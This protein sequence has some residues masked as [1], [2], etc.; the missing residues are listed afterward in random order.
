MKNKAILGSVMVILGFASTPAF[1]QAALFDFFKSTDVKVTPDKKYTDLNLVKN[2]DKNKIVVQEFFSFG[3]PHCSDFASQF[4]QWSAKQPK[5]VTVEKIPVTFDR[6]E[7]QNMAKLYYSLKEMNLG[8]KDADVFNAIHKERV[9]LWDQETIYSWVKSKDIDIDKFKEVYNSEK[10][11][12]Q[13][14]N[15]DMLSKKYK[16]DGVP[17]IVIGDNY[18]ISGSGGF[19]TL[20]KNSDD[21]IIKIH[22][23]DNLK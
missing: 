23:G 22:N 16:I 19:D 11:G 1:S 10:V 13:V 6:P 18:K 17:S 14:K 9:K 21:V 8:S 15:G 5:Y 12:S 7:W 2:I 3:C 4:N 20:L